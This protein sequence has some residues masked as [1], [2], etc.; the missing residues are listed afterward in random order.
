[1]G[2]VVGQTPLL[3]CCLACYAHAAGW[4]AVWSSLLLLLLCCLAC[5]Q[6]QSC[7]CVD[8]WRGPN[9]G[10]E[11]LH[12]CCHHHQLLLLLL[13][14]TQLQLAACCCCCCCAA[15]RPQA[16]LKNQHALQVLWV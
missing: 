8:A 14:V 3:F 2:W 10:A 6:H 1:V 5:H 16:L 11:L 9:D 4:V 12:R 15:A 7:C 13:V